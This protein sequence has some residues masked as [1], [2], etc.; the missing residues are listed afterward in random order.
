MCIR[1]RVNGVGEIT[2]HPVEAIEKSY[3]EGV[4]D[5]FLKPIIVSENNNLPIATISD[6]DVVFC[7]NFRTDRGREITEVLSQQ[8]FPDF[9]MKKLNLYYVTLTNYDESFQNVNVVFD[10]EVLQNTMGEVLERAGRT[11]ILSLIHI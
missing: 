4:T 8:D 1:D 3:A 7:F 5:E 6:N 9:G 2:K 11:Q 10:E